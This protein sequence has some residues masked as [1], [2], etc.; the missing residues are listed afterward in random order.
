MCGMFGLIPLILVSFVYLPESFTAIYEGH[1]DPRIWHNFWTSL[2]TL[3]FTAVVF[4]IELLL[5]NKA[6][7]LKKTVRPKTSSEFA[8]NSASDR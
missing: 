3:T 7:G 4:W 6:T 8:S 2:G 5:L 1:A